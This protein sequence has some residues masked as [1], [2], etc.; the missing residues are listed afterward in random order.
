VKI[1][2]FAIVIFLAL[3][4]PVAAWFFYKPVR[5]LFPELAGVVCVN[6]YICIEDIDKLDVA[7]KLYQDARNYVQAEISSFDVPPTFVFC[8]TQ[9]CFEGFGFNKA[10]AQSVATAAVVV[11][12]RGWRPHVMKHEMIHHIQNEKL[13]MIRFLSMPPWFV[14]GMAYRLSQ[15]P[16]E[17]LTEPWESYKNTFDEWYE[18][19]DP[20]SFWQ[21][22]EKL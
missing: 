2:V 14:E 13:G 1:R 19:I 5:V 18:T 10:S 21:E 11:G 3:A 17:I 4:I 9:S 22:A 20:E 16:R 15:D 6:K 12:P 7:E 8:K